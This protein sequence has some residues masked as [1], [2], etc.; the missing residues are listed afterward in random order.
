MF[1]VLKAHGAG[2]LL[3]YKELNALCELFK[4]V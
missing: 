3:N 1:R 4:L 2:F